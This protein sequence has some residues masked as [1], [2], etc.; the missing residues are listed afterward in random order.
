MAE[1]LLSFCLELI[2]VFESA[3]GGKWLLSPD[4]VLWMELVR[5]WAGL[6]FLSIDLMS[7]TGTLD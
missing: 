6:D 5:S 1:E 3:L 4:W 7:W 2:W